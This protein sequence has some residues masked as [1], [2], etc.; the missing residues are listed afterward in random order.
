MESQ[1]FAGSPASRFIEPLESFFSRTEVIRKRNKRK[2]KMLLGCV[3]VLPEEKN[4]IPKNIGNAYV[5][6]E[7]PKPRLAFKELDTNSA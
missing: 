3:L 1:Q 5:K 6:E 2:Y 7:G 4:R